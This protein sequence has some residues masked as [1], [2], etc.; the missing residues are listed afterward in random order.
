MEY[1]SVFKKKVILTHATTQVN[2]E[3]TTLSNI[4]QAQKDKYW[5]IPLIWGP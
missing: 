3:D 5:M 2:L 4:S 1:Y